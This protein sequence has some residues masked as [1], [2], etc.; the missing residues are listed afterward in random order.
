MLRGVQR[1]MRRDHGR[2]GAKKETTGE[3]RSRTSLNHRKSNRAWKQRGIGFEMGVR[4]HTRSQR[5][6]RQ[7]ITCTPDTQPQGL[8]QRETYTTNQGLSSGESG[9]STEPDQDNENRSAT[10]E[11]GREKIQLIWRETD[12]D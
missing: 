6:P 11:E 1:S 5:E 12:K 7:T 8:F 2:E 9:S 3:R 10:G 4:G